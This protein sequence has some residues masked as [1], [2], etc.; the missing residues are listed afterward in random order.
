MRN[1]Y[2][3]DIV[4]KTSKKTN[5]KQR[6]ERTKFAKLNFGEYNKITVIFCKTYFAA[7]F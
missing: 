6:K 2:G 3:K 5:K 1:P 7:I 4:K